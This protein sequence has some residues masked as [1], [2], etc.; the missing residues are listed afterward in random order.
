MWVVSVPAPERERERA[1]SSKN[2]AEEILALV[3]AVISLKVDYSAHKCCEEH[4]LCCSTAAGKQN[5][6]IPEAPGATLHRTTD[7]ILSH[8]NK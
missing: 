6:D 4:L 5:L 1:S 8:V 7:H 3:Q 2:A